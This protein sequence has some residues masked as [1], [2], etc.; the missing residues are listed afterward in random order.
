MT[1]PLSVYE[2][3]SFTIRFR[4]TCKLFIV[5][6]STTLQDISKE[7]CSTDLTLNTNS[8]MLHGCFN[9]RE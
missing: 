8:S 7:T 9:E 6:A 1:D 3:L 5:S 2:R 4:A